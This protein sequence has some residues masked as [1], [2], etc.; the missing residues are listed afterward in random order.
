MDEF[1][2]KWLGRA[3]LSPRLG[4]SLMSKRKPIAY[5]SLAEQ[6]YSLEECHLHGWVML[7]HLAEP[8]L[9]KH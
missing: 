8:I 7:I 1:D 9:G 6:E 2:N 4:F 5:Y 3:T